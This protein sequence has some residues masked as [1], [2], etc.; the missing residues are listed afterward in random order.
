MSKVYKT[1]ALA[2]EVMGWLLV[3]TTIYSF[4]SSFLFVDRDWATDEGYRLIWNI[5]VFS[6]HYIE[7]TILALIA[8]LFGR[9][10]RSYV[11]FETGDLVRNIRRAGDKTND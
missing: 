2:L 7:A 4:I 10:I 9:I 3:A 11:K 8:I 5:S 6:K 1:V